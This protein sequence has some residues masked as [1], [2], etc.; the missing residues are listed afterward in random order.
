ML[1]DRAA[2]AMASRGK[3]PCNCQEVIKR[4]RMKPSLIVKDINVGCS[5]FDDLTDTIFVGIISPTGLDFVLVL[6]G[7]EP[8]E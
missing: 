3:L 8:V 7:I 5:H 4:V 2:D 6:H 1:P